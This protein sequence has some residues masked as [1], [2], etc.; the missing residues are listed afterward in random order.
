MDSPAT[1]IDP[2]APSATITPTT[3][4]EI[5]ARM[6]PTA[7]IAMVIPGHDD[8]H[9]NSNSC[10]YRTYGAAACTLYNPGSVDSTPAADSD[11]AVVHSFGYFAFLAIRAGGG[12]RNVKRLVVIDGWFPRD[13]MWGTLPVSPGVPENVA[14]T[15]FFPT[16]G[17]R[18]GYSLE[19]VVRQAMVNRRDI[20]VVRGVGY[21]HNL[22]HPPHVTP[23]NVRTLVSFLVGLPDARTSDADIVT[24]AS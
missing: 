3:P 17:D 19:A 8:E 5:G 13:K 16:Y 1:G 12:A 18:S 2:D 4:A 24:Y 22:L 14:C 6:P 7:K 11:I 15:F 10:L 23:A 9:F 21:G 20:T